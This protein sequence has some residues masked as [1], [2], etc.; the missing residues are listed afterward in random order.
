V[1]LVEG[2]LRRLEGVQREH[3]KHACK[4][5]LPA[6]RLAETVGQLLKRKQQA[7]DWRPKRRRYADRC[8]CAAARVS[9]WDHSRAPNL[10]Q[11]A[12]H[13]SAAS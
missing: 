1:A 10:L 13:Q 4:K 9:I 5:D 2:M 6:K 12:L 8:A 11:H 7:A 3:G